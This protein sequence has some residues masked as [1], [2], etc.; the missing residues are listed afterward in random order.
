MCTNIQSYGERSRQTGL[1]TDACNTMY[2][3]SVHVCTDTYST[4]GHVLYID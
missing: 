4:E 2:M 1:Y 3:Y